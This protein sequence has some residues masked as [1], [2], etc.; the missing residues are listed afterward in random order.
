ME[1]NA[2]SPDVHPS[3]LATSMRE[4]PEKNLKTSAHS[5]LVS[6][7]HSQSLPDTLRQSG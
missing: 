1:L 7:P 5:G 2:G 3:H 4:G 6:R